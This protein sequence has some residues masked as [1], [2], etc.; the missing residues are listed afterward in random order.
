MRMSEY[1]DFLASKVAEHRPAGFDVTEADIDAKLFPFQRAVVRWA[2]RLGRCAIFADCGLGKTFM[3][4]E[5]AYKIASRE[6]RPVLI[7][8]PL[9]VAR[10]TAAEA[11]K[12]NNLTAHVVERQGEVGDRGIH[13]TNYHKLHKFD[14]AAFSGVVLDESSILKNYM[15]KTKRALVD[16][17]RDTPYKLCCTATPAPNDHMELGNHSEFLGVMDSN[18]MLSRWFVNDQA[19]TGSYRLKGHAAADYWRW[20]ASWAVCLSKPSDLGFSD[21]GFALPALNV[22]H[23]TVKVDAVTGAGDG[24][25]FRNDRLTATTMHREMRLT[26]KDRVAALAGVIDGQE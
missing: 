12:L 19:K 9:A 14:P 10:Q 24:R 20:V 13:I 11:A 17:F 5:W 6:P 2:L 25:L 22:E 15:G 26:A 18:E 23:H 7:L 4:L 21:E 1:N 16:A 3:Q 8:T